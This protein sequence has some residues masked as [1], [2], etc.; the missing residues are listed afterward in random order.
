M[1]MKEN[2]TDLDGAFQE[3]RVSTPLPPHFR[4]QVWQRIERAEQPNVSVADVLRAWLR[5][6]FLQPA[7]TVA[8]VTVLLMF[9]LVLGFVQA[10]QQNT[11]MER[12]LETRYVQIVDP[13]QR[14]Q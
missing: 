14:G 13:Y 1:N 6:R 7:F 3:W 10:N 2:P 9:G 11:K 5:Q 12:Q 8:Y 4:E